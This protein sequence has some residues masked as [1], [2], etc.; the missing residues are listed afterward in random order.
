[1]GDVET[2][3]YVMVHL[4]ADGQADLASR[5]ASRDAAKFG[6]DTRWHRNEFGLPVLDDALAWMQLVLTSRFRVGDH[7]LVI[8][9]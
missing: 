8:G 3:R 1:M 4:L 5:F 6:P 9:R 2:A 7:A